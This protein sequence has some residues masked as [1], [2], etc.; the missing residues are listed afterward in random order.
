MRDCDVDTPPR[1]NPD[2]PTLE[3]THNETVGARGRARRS[4]TAGEEILTS[5][6]AGKLE[7]SGWKC[8]S[9]HF[10][11]TPGHAH[12]SSEEARLDCSTLLYYCCLSYWMPVG[13]GLATPHT[14]PLMLSDFGCGSLCIQYEMSRTP[15]YRCVVSPQLHDSA[16]L[17]SSQLKT[18]TSHLLFA[19]SQPSLFAG[20]DNYALHWKGC[21]LQQKNRTL[22]DRAVL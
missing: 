4:Y 1:T 15:T 6:S 12:N 22:C 7:L 11:G 5:V 10:A 16:R 14:L 13:D 17:Y 19:R 18:D 21:S 8:K 9:C 3:T 2:P 20:R